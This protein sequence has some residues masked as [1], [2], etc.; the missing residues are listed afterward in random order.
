MHFTEAK[1]KLDTC[2]KMI[3]CNGKFYVLTCFSKVYRGVVIC[4]TTKRNSVVIACL[5]EFNIIVLFLK[6]SAE[7][8]TEGK[9]LYELLEAFMNCCTYLQQN[10][11]LSFE[12]SGHSYSPNT[13]QEKRRTFYQNN[14]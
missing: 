4:E 5:F 6:L 13:P 10:Q 9:N 12:E 1:V 11:A 2:S 14:P 7:M 8:I 3:T